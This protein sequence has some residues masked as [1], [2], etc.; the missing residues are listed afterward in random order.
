MNNKDSERKITIATISLSF[1]LIILALL[2]I[3]ILFKISIDAYYELANKNMT[4]QELGLYVLQKLLKIWV[5]ILLILAT[6]V[7][8]F[9]LSII[10]TVIASR[11][12]DQTPFILLIVGFFVGIC[13]LVGLFLL[14]KQQSVRT[15]KINS[16]QKDVESK[17]EIKE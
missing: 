3:I 15:E 8:L 12:K 11:Y 7:A 1:V 2:F 16:N 4:D 9:A 6:G 14:L 10:S 17:I 5:L 13:R